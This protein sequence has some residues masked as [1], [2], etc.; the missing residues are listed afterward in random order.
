[1]QVNTG[2]IIMLL[3]SFMIFQINFISNPTAELECKRVVEQISWKFGD[4]SDN[5]QEHL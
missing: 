5:L 1:M 2:N 4:Y 3:L